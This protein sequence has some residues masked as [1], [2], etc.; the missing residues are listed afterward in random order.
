M[1]I[2][3]LMER[4]GSTQTGRIIEYV[5]D[6]LNEL[7]SE[8]ETHTAVATISIE[9]GKR[10]YNLPNQ[11]VRILDVRCKD[12]NNQDGLYES[13]PR[14]AYEPATEDSDGF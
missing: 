7:N 13:I 5:K 4:V 12:H 11:S 9:N 3:Q 6:G 14:M 2:E 10:F 8:S 1:T